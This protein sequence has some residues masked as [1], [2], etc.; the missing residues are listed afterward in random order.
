MLREGRLG[1]LAERL[2]VAINA[3][4]YMPAIPQHAGRRRMVEALNRDARARLFMRI[5]RGRRREVVRRRAPRDL[6]VR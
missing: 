4:G 5:P 2:C 6:A 1:R 3:T